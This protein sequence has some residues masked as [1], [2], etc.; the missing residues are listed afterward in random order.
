VIDWSKSKRKSSRALGEEQA[1]QFLLI[2]NDTV[3]ING[4]IVATYPPEELHNNLVFLAFVGVFK[5]VRWFQFL[6][7]AGNYALLNARLRFIWESIFRAFWAENN[8]AVSGLSLDHKAAWL[9]KQKATDL[10]WNHCIKPSLF[11]VFPLAAREKMVEDDYHRLWQNLNEYVHPTMALV[12]R[13]IGPASLLHLD[14]FEKEWALETLD[15]A[16]RVFDLVWLAGLQTFPLAWDRLE[17]LEVDYPILKLVFDDA[18][19]T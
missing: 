17:G 8:P 1:N 5:E 4:T 14:G 13:M 10:N 2:A 7:L 15:N 11:R 18:A 3:A 9:G 6:F 16:R 12:A 19:A